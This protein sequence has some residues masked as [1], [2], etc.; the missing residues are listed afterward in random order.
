M[1]IKFRRKNGMTLVE[2]LLSIFILGIGL[3]AVLTTFVVG[4]MSV[5][6]AKHRI[7]VRNIL[8]ARME[9]LKNTTYKDIVS[10]G[11]DNVIIDPGPDLIEATSD[12]LTGSETITVIDKTGYKQVTLTLSWGELGWG[13]DKTVSEEVVT[14][15]YK[16]SV[17]K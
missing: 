7:E 11:P 6:R 16:W 12:D 9:T 10:S 8:R 17:Y 2:T 14:Y 15:I 3:S 4:K 1:L 5:A 13:S